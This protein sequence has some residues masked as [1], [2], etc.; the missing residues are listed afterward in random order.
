MLETIDIEK[1]LAAC[2]EYP[3]LSALSVAS[4]L[5]EAIN[6]ILPDEH[7]S[8]SAAARLHFQNPGKLLRGITSLRLS[9]GIGLDWRRAIDWAVAVELM[10]NASLVHDDICDEDQFRR[11]Q[12]SVVSSFGTPIAVCLGDWLVARSFE[13]GV[14]AAQD[15]P[16]TRV[17]EILASA[18]RRLS[19]GEAAEFSSPT[20]LEWAD[21]EEIVLHKTVPLISASIEGPLLLSDREANTADIRSAINA[22]GIAYQI[23]ND[24]ADILDRD[25]KPGPF[26]DLRKRSPNAVLLSFREQLSGKVRD[27]YDAW[28]GDLSGPTIEEWIAQIHSSVS[29]DICSQRLNAKLDDFTNSCNKLPDYILEALD[30]ILAY[31]NALTSVYASP[32]SAAFDL[33]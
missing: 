12:F 5:T 27:E 8:L 16:G 1:S 19:A 3:D 9:K 21:Y 32:T 33:N 15:G 13:L 31:L 4:N 6:S 30:P 29:L 7:S 11:D 20:L 24:M 28:W 18:M 17:I 10:H 22:L 2:T 26:N 23:S 25:G 14:R